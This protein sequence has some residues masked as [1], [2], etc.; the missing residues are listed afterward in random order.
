MVL[1]VHF[2]HIGHFGN[3]GTFWPFWPLLPFGSILVIFAIMAIMVPNGA[4]RGAKVARKGSRE[5]LRSDLRPERS[6]PLN[7]TT[8]LCFKYIFGVHG[9][10]GI[11]K[12]SI[13]GREIDPGGSKIDPRG[14]TITPQ[15]R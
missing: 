14:T 11:D 6:K 8:A 15:Q 4:Q 12:K 7:L 1:L 13:F 2:G 9:G 5:A 3:Y 10:A